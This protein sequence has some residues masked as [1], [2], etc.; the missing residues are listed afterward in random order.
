M[1]LFLVAALALWVLALGPA[2]SGATDQA[3]G[4]LAV[5]MD[6][7]PSTRNAKPAF[8]G[9]ELYSWEAPGKGF[10]FV[11]LPGTNRIKTLAE[12]VTAPGRDHGLT[13]LKRALEKLP[14]GEEV[15]WFNRCDLGEAAGS[16]SN[17]QPKI[18]LTFPG[19]KVVAHLIK[20]GEKHRVT[21]AVP[22]EKER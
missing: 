9:V 6:R 22:P 14:A 18:K 2:P 16:G 10:T 19:P 17:P 21:L 1:R 15:F 12:I 7:K 3:K 11:L 4:D 8:K 5:G 13:S 20:V